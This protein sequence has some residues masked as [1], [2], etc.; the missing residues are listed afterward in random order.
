[1]DHAGKGGYSMKRWNETIIDA[2]RY[3]E[4]LAYLVN[5]D[6]SSSEPVGA[7]KVAAFFQEQYEQ[8]GWQVE[9]LQLAPSIGPCLKITN[10]PAAHYDLL[11]WLIWIRF[12]RW[13]QR[14]NV[15]SAEMVIEPWGQ[16]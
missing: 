6:S 9:P 3:Q 14:Q 5:I 15:R 7:G 11:C 1:M 12:F 13:E 10:G 16:V 8:L 4:E 2:A